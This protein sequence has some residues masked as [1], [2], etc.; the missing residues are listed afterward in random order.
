[1]DSGNHLALSESC[2][3][4]EDSSHQ[5]TLCNKQNIETSLSHRHLQIESL[6]LDRYKIMLQKATKVITMLRRN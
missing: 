3:E 2:S 6:D 5:Q 1:M 4:G